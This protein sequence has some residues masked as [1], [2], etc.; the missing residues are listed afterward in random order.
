[1]SR[2]RP[3]DTAPELLTRRALWHRGLRYRLKSRLPGKPDIVF[4]KARVAVFIDGCFW[5]GCTLHKSIPQHNR[6]FWEKKIKANADRDLRVT[7]ELTS[8]GWIVKRY[9]EHQVK[10]DLD[11]VVQEIYTLVRARARQNGKES[12]Q[13]S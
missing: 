4:P 8:K 13:V 2:N 7:R 11:C 5:H 10:K 6:E 12:A 1:M 3:R 9:W